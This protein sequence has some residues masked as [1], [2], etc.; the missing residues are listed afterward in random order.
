MINDTLCR[1]LECI[2]KEKHEYKVERNKLFVFGMLTCSPCDAR[3]EERASTA[4]SLLLAVGGRINPGRRSAG[5]NCRAPP[6]IKL[7]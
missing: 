7:Q 4:V 3:C 1:K 5:K 2:T 6:T